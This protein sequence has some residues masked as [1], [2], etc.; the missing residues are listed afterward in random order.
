MEKTWISAILKVLTDP[1]NSAGLHY[2]EITEQIFIQ[3]LYKTDGATPAA[4]VNSIISASIK[5]DNPSSFQRV[6]KGRFAINP[7]YEVPPGNPIHHKQDEAIPAKTDLQVDATNSSNETEHGAKNTVINAFGMYWKRD[8]IVWRPSAVKLLG[9][10]SVGAKPVN[11]HKQRGIYIL[12]DYHTVVYVGRVI[13]RP[14]G[15]RLYEH[16][17]D[18]LNSRWNRFSWFGLYNVTDD[19]NL[20]DMQS[21]SSSMSNLIIAL[22]AVL[23]EALEPPQ[24][25]RRGDDF[26]DQEYIQDVDPE[27]KKIEVKNTMRI[28]EEKLLT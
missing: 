25:R 18:R 14:M 17:I 15:K 28:I 23:I 20:Q 11:F 9:R 3:N 2:S 19:G 8:Y 26:S 12:Y 24:N 10:Q 7:E 5:H 13:D 16:T 22:E 1:E 6:G 27:L 4:T 21:Q